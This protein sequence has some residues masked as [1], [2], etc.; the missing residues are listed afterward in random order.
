MEVDQVDETVGEKQSMSPEPVDDASLNGERGVE[1]AADCDEPMVSED[2]ATSGNSPE[3]VQPTEQEQPAS[4]E[5]SANEEKSDGRGEKADDSRRPEKEAAGDSNDI[6]HDTEMVSEDEFSVEVVKAPLETEEVSDEE[7]PASITENLETE[8]VSDD[9]LPP[10]GKRKKKERSQDSNESDKEVP[11]KKGKIEKD[12]SPPTD[13][14]DEGEKSTSSKPIHPAVKSDLVPELE[15][16]WK[17]VNEDPTDFTGWTYLLQ[18]VDQ[19]SDVDA[20]REVYDAF[21]ALYPYCYG[22]WRKYADYEKRKGDKHK[23]EE[24]FLRGLKAIPLSIDLWI[25]YLNYCKTQYKDD[26][27]HIRDEYNRAIETCGLEF[28]SDK[29]WENYIK[30]ELEGKH[31][32][33]TFL[34]YEKLLSTPTQGYKTHFQNFEEFVRTTQPNKIL[35]TDEFLSLRSEVLQKLRSKPLGKEVNVPPSAAPPGDDEGDSE[36]PSTAHADEETTLIRERI[37]SSR[38]KLYKETVTAV[39]AR[40]NFEEGIKRP[41]FHVKPLERSQLIT[42]KEYLDFEIGQGDQKR[43]VILFERCLIACALYQEFWVKFIKYLE[44]LPNDMSEKIRDVYERACLIHHPKKA[45]LSLSWATF[46]ENLG[47]V[48]EARKIL[49]KL[50]ENVPNILHVSVRRINLER[51]SG[52]VEAAASLYEKYIANAKSKANFIVLSI[53]YA[54]FCWKILNNVKRGIHVL[55]KAIEKDSDNPRLYSQLVELTLML[56][57][58]DEEECLKIFNEAIGNETMDLEYRRIFAQRKIEFLEDFGSSI[59]SLREAQVEYND[60]MKELR[61]KKKLNSKHDIEKAKQE[62]ILKNKSKGDSSSTNAGANS[63]SAS[64]TYPQSGNYIQ[65]SYDSSSGGQYSQPSSYQQQPF[66]QYSQPDQSYSTT[67][68]QNWTYSQTTGYGNYNQN[69]GGYNY[70]S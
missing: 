27:N 21:L 62:D 12:R 33:N 64:S 46:E 6:Q 3:E 10:L 63:Y 51:R 16:Y 9:E 7:L 53:K 14:K 25:N 36:E 41:Y 23:S 59:K 35:N 56:Q 30:W 57:P 40:W 45:F 42:W 67:G 66:S 50:E 39:L 37:I 55:R 1:S 31:Y 70:Y 5:P 49:Q 11:N 32:Q 34:L 19:E 44:E 61:E 29:L 17:P 47:N 58:L 65:S 22:Y 26:E 15:K 38:K 20:A 43:T 28:R 8:A 18:Y 52:N 68:Y 24:V 13:E 60:I 54:R 2:V 48:D 4:D 69:W